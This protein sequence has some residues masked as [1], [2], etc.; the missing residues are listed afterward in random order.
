MDQDDVEEFPSGRGAARF[1]LP[2]QL[3]TALLAVAI[4]LG[5]AVGRTV[6]G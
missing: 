4:I 5:G 6:F 1:A 3:A 2:S